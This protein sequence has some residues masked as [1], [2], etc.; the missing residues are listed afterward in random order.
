MTKGA[1]SIIMNF[2]QEGRGDPISEKRFI[3]DAGKASDRQE[4][5]RMRD[6][7]LR[8]EA[9]S[10]FFCYDLYPGIDL[11]E[12]GSRLKKLIKQEGYSV[13]EIQK[14]LHLSCPQP[15]YRWMKGQMLPTVDHLYV[16]A[17]IFRVHME[18]LLVQKEKGLA[19]LVREKNGSW[20]RR[21]TAYRIRVREA[22]I[23][24]N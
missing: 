22:R 10:L 3:R 12:T 4:S 9:K 21:L 18:E 7:G 13:S 17:K 24:A 6:A 14:L 5:G 8:G 2:R 1:F 16:L 20:R 19:E 15:V 11:G 23:N